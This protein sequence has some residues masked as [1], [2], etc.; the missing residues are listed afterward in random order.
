[1][2][3]IYRIDIQQGNIVDQ[4][5]VDQLRPHMSKRQVL[6]IMGSPMLKEP[7]SEKRWD[8]LYYNKASGKDL[9]QKK[10]YLFFENDQVVGIQG[11]FKPGSGAASKPAPE[12]TVNVPKRDLER[13]LWEKLTGI[14]DYDDEELDKKAAAARTSTDNI[15]KKSK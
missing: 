1:M 14:F 9:E 5:M 8:Y 13:T 7:F 15:F 11:D 6:F 10:L 12:L 2:P 4:A 3:G